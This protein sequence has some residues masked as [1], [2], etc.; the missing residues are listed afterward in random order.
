MDRSRRRHHDASNEHIREHH[1]IRR[2]R[3]GR[4]RSRR[5]RNNVEHR[6]RYKR[7]SEYRSRSSDSSN[8]KRRV[9][10]KRS[11]VTKPTRSDD[12][13]TKR[14]P[15]RDRVAMRPPL[16]SINATCQNADCSLTVDRSL[17]V[18]N[19]NFW[20]HNNFPVSFS[21]V[22]EFDPSDNSQ[23]MESWIN[24]VNECAQIY[25]WNDRQVCHYALPKLTGLAKRW[26]QGL[27]SV[28]FSWAMWIEK[29]KLAFPSNENYGDLLSSML[30]IRCRFG[31]PLERIT[32]YSLIVHFISL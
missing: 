13:H 19:I 31:Q 14:T 24:K 3:Q 4:S 2:S 11:K 10:S 21:V 17:Q 5:D 16:P 30:K 7:Y 18:P 1:N 12:H 32:H 8:S 15:T 25:S 28:L 29:L 6:R 26:Y 22:P 27:P 23:T 9:R 20:A